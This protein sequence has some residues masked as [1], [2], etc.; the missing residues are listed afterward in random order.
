MSE[1]K[2]NASY[3]I[4]R[5]VEE[6]IGFGIMRTFKRAETPTEAHLQSEIKNEVMN[7]LWEVL[8]LSGY[9]KIEQMGQGS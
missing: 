5:A 1:L 8:D 6:G 9:I 4:E 3:I 2:F 7:A